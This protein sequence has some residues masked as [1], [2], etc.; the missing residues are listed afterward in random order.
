MHKNQVEMLLLNIFYNGIKEKT[1]IFMILVLIIW[2]FFAV[3]WL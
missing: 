1:S 2:I 3:S